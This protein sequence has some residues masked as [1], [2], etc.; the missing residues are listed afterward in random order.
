MGLE[1]YYKPFQS[2]NPMGLQR[3]KSRVGSGVPGWDTE[4]H[5]EMNIVSPLVT[6]HSFGE[7]G[8]VAQ[9]I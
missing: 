9:Q 3:G 6:S 1:Q 4:S 2:G 8:W 7:K 5:N